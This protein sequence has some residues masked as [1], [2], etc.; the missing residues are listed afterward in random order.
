M[1]FQ[2]LK[3]SYEGLKASQLQRS[4]GSG[5]GTS[6]NQQQAQLSGPE[7][8]VLGALAAAG[9]VAVMNPMDT[10]KTRLVTQVRTTV[11]QC[12]M[13]DDYLRTAQEMSINATAAAATVCTALHCIYPV[14]TLYD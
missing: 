5:T 12:S 13:R 9:G 4:A 11:Y 14:Q 7:S 1:F 8:F 10:I 6:N 2:Q 3:R